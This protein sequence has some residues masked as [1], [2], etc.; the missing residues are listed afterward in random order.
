MSETEGTRLR[1]GAIVR[2]LWNC[3]CRMPGG[4]HHVLV[5]FSSLGLCPREMSIVLNGL[6]VEA[7]LV[8]EEVCIPCN[9]DRQRLLDIL[10]GEFERE[11]LF[12]P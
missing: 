10:R 1:V 8:G 2:F 4:E 6:G 9:T 5:N 7:S 12:Q 3:G 11:H